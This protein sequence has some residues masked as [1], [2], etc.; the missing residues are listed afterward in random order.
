MTESKKVWVE[1]ELIVL[2]RNNPEEAVLMNCKD[3]V[4][5]GPTS[6]NYVCSTGGCTDCSSLVGS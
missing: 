2:V 3:G 5:A 6:N 4:H 1:P